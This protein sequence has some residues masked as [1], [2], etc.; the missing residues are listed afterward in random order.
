MLSVDRPNH[1]TTQDP[2][3][4]DNADISGGSYPVTPPEPV[5]PTSQ[6]STM[7]CESRNSNLRP[8]PSDVAIGVKLY[9]EF[10]HRQP[11]WLFERDEL[12]AD[13]RFPDELACSILALTSRFSE[14][15]NMLQVYGNN[16][17]SLIMHSIANGNVGLTTI[18]SLCLLAYS[19]FI[20]E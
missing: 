4:D 14:K 12:R 7:I 18:E 6:P 10:C 2:S 8:G 19:S 5:N 9:F 3:T 11:I 13:G 1:G 20:G 17:R 15:N 16:A